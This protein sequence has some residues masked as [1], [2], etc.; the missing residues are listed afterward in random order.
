M[1]E[2]VS[3][4]FPTAVIEVFIHCERSRVYEPV[5]TKRHSGARGEEEADLD[6]SP[7]VI[8]KVGVD[9]PIPKDP[10]KYEVP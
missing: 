4:T 9:V 10:P 2:I 6:G 5:T 3:V 8:A 1:F 7:I